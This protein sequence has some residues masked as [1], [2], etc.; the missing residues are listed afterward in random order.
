MVRPVEDESEL[1]RLDGGSSQLREQFVKQ[2]DELRNKIWDQVGYK[3]VNCKKVNIK[4]W[5]GLIE[6]VI[7]SINNNQAIPVTKIEALLSKENSW[8]LMN[9]II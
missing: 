1:Q 4:G 8:A 2:V 3:Q 9:S 5:I 7:A 6:Q